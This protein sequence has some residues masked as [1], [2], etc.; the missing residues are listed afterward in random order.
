MV[1]ATAAVGP[2]QCHSS[3]SSMVEAV[4]RPAQAPLD[5][6]LEGWSCHCCLSC[7]A[8]IADLAAAG[9]L[10]RLATFGRRRRA[11][12]IL[13]L[14]RGRSGCKN[15]NFWL[16][17]ESTTRICIQ[18]NELY[19]EPERL[20]QTG[21]HRGRMPSIWIWLGSFVASQQRGFTKCYHFSSFCS[22]PVCCLNL[23]SNAAENVVKILLI[24]MKIL[25]SN[26]YKLY[27]SKLMLKSSKFNEIW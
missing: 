22:T 16:N 23:G 26:I 10:A 13:G 24:F 18:T 20:T 19:M 3:S 8:L 9:L 21:A 17:Q 1:E 14:G 12:A 2:T 15:G 4:V 27:V 11:L 7:T 25:I 6:V 5:L